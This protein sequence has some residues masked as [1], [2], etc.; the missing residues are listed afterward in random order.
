MQLHVNQQLY[1]ILNNLSHVVQEAVGSTTGESD[2]SY[3]TTVV[4]SNDP[5]QTTGANGHPPKSTSVEWS[6]DVCRSR[7]D[8]RNGSFTYTIMKG[9]Y[10]ILVFILIL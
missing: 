6:A 7:D 8:L 1:E 5:C 4:E 3:P 9:Y 10:A 2:N